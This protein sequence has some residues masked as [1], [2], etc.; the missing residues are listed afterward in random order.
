MSS[1]K[2]SALKLSGTLNYYFPSKQKRSLEEDSLGK[3]LSKRLREESQTLN[4]AEESGEQTDHVECYRKASEQA[5]RIAELESKNRELLNDCKRLKKMFDEATKVNLQ[6]DLKINSI[7]TEKSN[8]RCDEPLMFANFKEFTETEKVELRSTSILSSAD[9]KFVT[10][11]L[12]MLYKENLQVL[13]HRTAE[14]SFEDKTPLTPKKKETIK[15]AY[16]ERLLYAPTAE[17][18]SRLNKLNAHLKNGIR[19]TA[20]SKAVKQNLFD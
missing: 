10:I 5:K 8:S 6:K 15:K 14:I 11:S 7:L 20:N 9:C 17:Y 2:G 4:L 1:K 12:R 3:I 13:A 18:T 19:N 16:Q